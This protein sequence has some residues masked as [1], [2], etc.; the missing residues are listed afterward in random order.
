MGRAVIIRLCRYPVYSCWFKI[1]CARLLTIGG[2]QTAADGNSPQVS[3]RWCS[4]SIR[5]NF[6]SP[7]QN[8][9]IMCLGFT[10]LFLPGI[11]SPQENQSRSGMK[12]YPLAVGNTWQY[13]VISDGK[14]SDMSWRVVNKT[15]NAAGTVF[16]VWPSPAQVDDQGMQ[17]QINPD[18][19]LELSANFYILQFPVG[20]GENWKLKDHERLFSV[21]SEGGPCTVGKFSFHKCAV[22][23]DDDKE[24][25]LRTVTTYAY[26]VGPV[27]YEYYKWVN[28]GFVRQSFHTLKIVSYSLK[29]IR[30]Q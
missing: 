11:L 2:P 5:G 20:A 30:R 12:Y 16:A 6:G 25:N 1:F 24:A 27:R 18:G 9:L 26:H 22:V 14:G 17:L 3:T 21:L 10:L 19:L 15:T 7:R 28:G 13:S 8:S 29:S 23:Q 4:M